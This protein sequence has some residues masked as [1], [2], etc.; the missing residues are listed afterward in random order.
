MAGISL[1]TGFLFF[2][3]ME[4]SEKNM[5]RVTVQIWKKY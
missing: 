3:H 4:F 2:K 5:G 1:M